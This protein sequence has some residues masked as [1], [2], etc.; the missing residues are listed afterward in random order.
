ML[1][2]GMSEIQ[3]S[4]VAHC[5]VNAAMADRLGL[6]ERVATALLQTFAQ[7]D[8]KGLPKG[9]GGEEMLLAIRIAQ[10]ANHVEV[11]AREQDVEASK[12]VARSLAGSQ[13]D[14]ALCE[15]WCDSADTLL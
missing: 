12:H 5:A 4:F 14:P 9:V 15:L 10:L 2:T 3:Q 11:V 7:W 6:G 8:G 1:L 13:Y